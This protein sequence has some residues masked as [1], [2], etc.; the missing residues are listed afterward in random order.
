[1]AGAGG[2]GGGGGDDAAAS[3]PEGN[4]GKRF[5]LPPPPPFSRRRMLSEQL[6][7]NS[8]GALTLGV[9][10]TV[11]LPAASDTPVCA[12]LHLAKLS[13]PWT[14][15]DVTPEDILAVRGQEGD[16]AQP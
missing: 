13:D 1:M 4:G 3:E 11:T 10:S 9:A 14:C 8:T 16:G 5:G 15:A 7:P 6:T 2:G 12:E